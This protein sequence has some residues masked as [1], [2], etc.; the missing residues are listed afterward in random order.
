MK[1]IKTY[2]FASMT[3]ELVSKAAIDDTEYYSKFLSQRAPNVTVNIIC[4]ELPSEK[5]RVIAKTDKK[6]V[7]KNDSGIFAYTSYYDAKKSELVPYACKA[8]RGKNVDLYVD[9]AGGLWDKMIFNA[10]DI[11]QMMIRFDSALIHCSVVEHNRQA[12]LFAGSSGVGKSTQAAL[13]QKHRGAKIINGDRGAICER[14]GV[15]CV[16]GVPFNG[17]SAI[18]N[19][20]SRKIEMLVFLEHGERNELVEL[21]QASAFKMLLGQTTYYEWDRESVE[22]TLNILERFVEAIPIFKLKCLPDEG[23]VKALEDGYERYITK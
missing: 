9:Y 11:P 20:I 3:V 6:T 18:C 14:D 8:Q 13:W 5:G 7:L 1:Y 4:G 12:I 22:K 17:T 15:F 19:N 21:T 23:A 10:L 2:S 16:Y